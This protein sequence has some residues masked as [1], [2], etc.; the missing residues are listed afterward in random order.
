MRIAM[1]QG[2]P[3]VPVFCFGQ[4]KDKKGLLTGVTLKTCVSLFLLQSRAYKW[5]KP[6]CD[7]YFKLARAIRFTPICFWGV[8]G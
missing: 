2:A 6:D 7:L 8:L 5:W 3:L 4:V 1:E